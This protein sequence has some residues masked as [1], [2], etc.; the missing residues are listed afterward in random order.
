M[1]LR[2]EDF[3]R[4]YLVAAGLGCYA[5][6]FFLFRFVERPGLGLGHIFYVAIVLVAVTGGVITG[7]SA[8]ILATALYA[9][10][11]YWNPRVP[12]GSLATV[13]TGIRLVSY[14][15]VGTLIGYYAARS[16][17]L[18]AR[19]EALTEELQVLARRDFVTGLPNQ[20]AFE[21]AINAR[22]S[23]GAPFDLVLCQAPPEP[24]GT[25]SLDWLLGIGERLTYALPAEADI[26]Q[27]SDHQFAVLL[28]ADQDRSGA[29]V[30]ASVEGAIQSFARPVAGWASYPSDSADALGLFTAASERLYAR[31]IAH[32]GERGHRPIAAVATS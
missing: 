26:A 7:A 17:T 27:I 10:D 24:L 14:L 1:S 4:H 20:R 5:A 3:S 19:A 13:A 18:L 2:R 9:I 29:S 11:V 32:G 28:S 12:T 23:A 22:I 31:S 15:T 25:S 8:G 6:V 21:I 30:T 16:R